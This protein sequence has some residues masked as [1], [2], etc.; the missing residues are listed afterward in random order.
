MPSF[1]E[2]FHEFRPGLH[3]RL[4]RDVRCAAFILGLIWRNLTVG[5]RVRRKYLDCVRTGEPFW[6]DDAE[7]GAGSRDIDS[8]AVRS[9]D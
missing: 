7:P 1:E 5:R 6:L 2:R 4:W 3:W 8:L 9:A